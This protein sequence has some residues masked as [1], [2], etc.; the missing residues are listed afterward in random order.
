LFDLD[1][2]AQIGGQSGRSR[3]RKI[4]AACRISVAP[5]ICRWI[6]LIIPS[7]D[8]SSSG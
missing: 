6:L 3:R 5:I 4:A 1:Y 8:F 7:V 2:T